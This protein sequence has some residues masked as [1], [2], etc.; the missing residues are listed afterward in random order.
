MFWFKTGQMYVA[1]L[2]EAGSMSSETQFG[3]ISVGIDHASAAKIVNLVTGKTETKPVT[4]VGSR[5]TIDG[6][7]LGS[8]PTALELPGI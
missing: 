3:N 2:W 7:P 8:Q 4:R 6:V 1:I 5:V